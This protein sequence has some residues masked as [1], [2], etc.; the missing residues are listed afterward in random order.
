MK[1][2]AELA[3]EWEA[4]GDARAL[5]E[6]HILEGLDTLEA[7]A[8]MR[9]PS[10]GVTPLELAVT[11]TSWQAL[12]LFDGGSA[13]P[14]AG[15]R[16]LTPSLAAGTLTVEAGGDGW[17]ELKYH[18]NLTSTEAVELALNRQRGVANAQAVESRAAAGVLS[19]CSGSDLVNLQEGDVLQLVG[20]TGAGLT[21]NLDIWSVQWTALRVL[22]T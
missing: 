11:G 22:P 8:A 5:T 6:D 21:A 17:Y 18:C 7:G 3:T 19:S 15:G 14:S 16:G 12:D 4:L 20:R 13:T 9:L 2:V 10:Q 1:T